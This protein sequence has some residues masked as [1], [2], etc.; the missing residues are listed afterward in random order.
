MGLTQLAPAPYHPLGKQFQ[1]VKIVI[2]QVHLD[3]K[4]RIFHL[5][6]L[7]EVELKKKRKKK[8]KEKEKEKQAWKSFS[9]LWSRE[10]V[11]VRQKKISTNELF[12][13]NHQKCKNRKPDRKPE[14]GPA[15]KF[16][17]DESEYHYKYSSIKFFSIRPSEVQKPETGQKT[18]SRTKKNFS[19]KVAKFYDKFDSLIKFPIY[20]SCIWNILQCPE[21]HNNNYPSLWISQN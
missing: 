11:P 7:R 13:Y 1:I 5:D 15:G 4:N 2:W 12:W 18:G 21:S 20:W 9:E 14:S 19:T 16:L 6:S 8:E 17:T 10:N 3:K